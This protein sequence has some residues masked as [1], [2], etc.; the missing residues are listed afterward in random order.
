[1]KV[2]QC[3]ERRDFDI[4]ERE[5]KMYDRFHHKNIVRYVRGL[6]NIITRNTWRTRLLVAHS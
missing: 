1:M 2:I 4:A 3:S 6:M 5:A